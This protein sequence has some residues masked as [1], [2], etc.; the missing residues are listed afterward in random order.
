MRVKV[1]KLG[2]HDIVVDDDC[3]K[4]YIYFINPDYVKF[5]PQGK[6]INEPRNCCELKCKTRE[7]RDA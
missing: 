7:K 3:P 5:E 1:G 2:S 4:G 6:P